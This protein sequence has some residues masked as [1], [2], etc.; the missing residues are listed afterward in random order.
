MSIK[1]K[2][3]EDFEELLWKYHTDDWKEG[4]YDHNYPLQLAVAYFDWADDG[5][6]LESPEEAFNRY[7]EN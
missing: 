3:V 6:P 7:K 2:W 1:R 5:L 4:N